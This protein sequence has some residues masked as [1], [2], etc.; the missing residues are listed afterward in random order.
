MGMSAFG[1]GG[2]GLSAGIK[3]T[4]AIDGHKSNN[5]HFFFFLNQALIE[6]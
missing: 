5:A 3:T 4:D 6:R 1:M 2:G